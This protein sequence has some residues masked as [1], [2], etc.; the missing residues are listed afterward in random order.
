MYINFGQKKSSKY[1]NEIF[2]LE[3]FD[4]KIIEIYKKKVLLE[5]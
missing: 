1:S 2:L 3:G 5:K 4:G